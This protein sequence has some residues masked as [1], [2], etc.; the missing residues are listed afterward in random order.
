MLGGQGVSRGSIS[1]CFFNCLKTHFNPTFDGG[2]QILPPP[3]ISCSG[4]PN[5]DPRAT[6]L[7]HNSYFIVTIDILNVF[8]PK[9]VPKKI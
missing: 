7:W 4:G 6:K 2:G 1:I 9:G 3:R 8:N 5:I